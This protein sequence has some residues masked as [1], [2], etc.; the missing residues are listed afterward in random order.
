MDQT[1]G[2]LFPPLGENKP[3]NDPLIIQAAVFN[4]EVWRVYLDSGSECNVIFEHCFLKLPDALRA[5]K[6]DPQGLLIGFSGEHAWPL[7]EIDVDITISDGIYEKTETLDLSKVRSPLPY[8]ILLGRTAMQRL[9]MVPSGIHRLVKF[10]SETGI[11]TI[12]QISDVKRAE[13]RSSSVPKDTQEEENTIKIIVN[14]NYPYQ[15]ISIGIHFSDGCKHKLRKLLQP[16]MDIFAWEYKD[17]TG[18]PRVL[19]L[20]GKPFVTEH[21]LNERKH[22]EPVHQKKRSLSADRDKAARKE[23]EELL[24][25]GIVRESTY[26]V[27]VANPVMVK[28]GD[29]GWRMCVDFTNI[30]KACPKDCHPLPEIDWKVESLTEHKLKCFLNLLLSKNAIC[31]KER[32]SYVP[33]VGRQG[34]R[35]TNRKEPGS[36]C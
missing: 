1:G 18:V 31:F 27:W 19:T 22:I 33:K 5:R 4:I 21:R 16:N 2:F 25:A 3:S 36:I 28:K 26:P 24:Q 17:M 9:E 34:L 12:K 35:H 14:P 32:R 6:V 8:N 20:E 13:D 30:N 23:V 11:G 10:Q 7:G 15:T 29:G